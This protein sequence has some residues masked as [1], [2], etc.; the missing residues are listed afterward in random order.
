MKKVG[1][2][3]FF[4]DDNFGTCLQAF[5]LQH[6]M[7]QFGYDV[8]LIRYHRAEKTQGDRD[9]R[10]KRIFQL[11]PRKTLWWL[12]NRKSILAKKTKFKEFRD[13]YLNLADDIDYY[14]NSGLKD[15]SKKY[16][17]LVCGSDMMWSSDFKADWAFYYLSFSEKRKN[18]SYAPSYGRNHLTEQEIAQCIPYINNISHLSCRELGGVDLIRQHFGLKAEHV[19]DP[20]LLMNKEEWN[21]IVGEDSLLE[22][23]NYIL[24]YLFNG[25]T[26]N[27][28]DKIM[29]QATQLPGSELVILM[30]AEG[31]FQR[32][33][34][35]EPTGPLEFIR[36]YRDA[37]F[38]ITDTFHGMLFAIIFNKPFIVLDK[39]TF[40]ISADRLVSTL[41]SLGIDNR[42][43]KADIKLNDEILNMDYTDVNRI[44]EK[45]QSKSISYLKS[46]L[47]DVTGK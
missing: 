12:I 3:T 17:A 42:Y 46:A 36:L 4:Y 8:S 6:V 27:G 7:E 39:S 1:L 45:S 16:D 34:Y 47:Y 43:V 30:G 35:P 40:G 37:K 10:W 32:Y 20:T 23:D 13:R 2:A 18:I 33:A 22:R 26:R 31:K 5:A 25:T 15:V 29:E 9:G 24:T 11:S 38:V 21:E 28:R 19:V 41:K 44:L 14:R